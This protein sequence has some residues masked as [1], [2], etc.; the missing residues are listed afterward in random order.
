MKKCRS[1][2][3]LVNEHLHSCPDCGADI[4]MFGDGTD[5]PPPP[6][7]APIAAG[8]DGDLLPDQV[9]MGEYAGFWIRF[10][11]IFLDGLITSVLILPFLGLVY[12]LGSSSLEESVTAVNVVGNLLSIVAWGINNIYLQSRYGWTIGKKICGLVVL[13]ADGEFMSI[14]RTLARE[15]FKGAISGCVC[16]LGYI[17][18]AFDADKQGWHDKVAG[19]YVYYD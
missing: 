5:A 13:T 12:A 10:A 8:P 18:V 3:K 6:A 11:A 7:G 1:C 4:E 16:M 14:G 15:I 2:G 17:W 19:T 9:T